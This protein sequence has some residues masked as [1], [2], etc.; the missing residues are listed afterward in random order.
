MSALAGLADNSRYIQISAPVQPGNSGGPLLDVSGHLVGIVTAKLDAARVARFTGDIPQNVNFALKA[1]VARTFLD[2]KGIAYQTARS[3]RK[4]SPADVGNIARPFTVHIEC[5]H[6]GTR[7]AAVPPKVN[8]PAYWTYQRLLIGHLNQCIDP[9]SSLEQT[10]EACTAIITA[11]ASS[12]LGDREHNRIA[13]VSFYKLRAKAYYQKGQYDLAIAD[14]T[15]AIHLDPTDGDAYY[16]RGSVYDDK[17]EYER[18]I[19]DFTKAYISD[20]VK[21]A[22]SAATR[23]GLIYLSAH[24]HRQAMQW[25]RAAAEKGDGIAMTAIGVIYAEAKDCNSARDWINKGLA[26]GDETAKQALRSGVDG[27]CHW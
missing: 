16:D 25:F 6:S 18:A 26:A 3:D 13:Q 22:A 2:S 10:I 4:L 5:E 8:S 24:D 9:N 11:V 20:Y 17:H 12:A 23:I 19:N 7:S 21:T 15:D 1:E 14:Y 27:L